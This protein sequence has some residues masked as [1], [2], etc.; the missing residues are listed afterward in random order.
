MLFMHSV[1]KSYQAGAFKHM[2]AAGV[3]SLPNTTRTRNGNAFLQSDAEWIF[4]V[5]TDMVWEPDAIITLR[6]YA[7]K[8][9]IKAI[10]GWTVS[11]KNGIWPNAYLRD[12]DGNFV[13][14]GEIEPM[15]SPIPVDAVGGSNF[16]VHRDIYEAIAEETRGTTGYLWQDIEYSE[17]AD[18]MVGEDLVFCD[19]IARYTGE[20]IWYHPGAIFTHIKPV[21][22]GPQEYLRFIE[23]LKRRA[24]A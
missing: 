10:S 5:D 7:E 20:Q 19:R 23:G 14:Y 15:S 6:Q 24:N 22:F 4:L 12:P 16:L 11:M 13:P 18:Y 1:H 2:W 9:G 8:H 3:G 21:P 17:S